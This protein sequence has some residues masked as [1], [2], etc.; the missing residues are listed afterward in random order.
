M[1]A[2][3]KNFKVAE[4]HVSDLLFVPL[5]PK[6]D[7]EQYIK[8]R[9]ATRTKEFEI[10]NA[11]DTV[12]EAYRA[13]LGPRV[14][15]YM[16]AAHAVAT[17][18]GAT[19]AVAEEK[20]LQAEILRKWV[21]YL[22]PTEAVRPHLDEWRQAVSAGKIE[23]AA[24]AYQT[25]FDERWKTWVDRVA[26]WRERV[27]KQLE[28]KDTPLA[29][30]PK[31]NAEQ[32]AF[33]HDVF[34]ADGGPFALGRDDERK[35]FSA[36]TNQQL[37]TLRAELKHLRETAPPEPDM[38]CAVEEGDPVEQ[39]V[40]IRGDYNSLGEPAP[41]IFPAI[42]E[43]F[44]QEPA[45]EGSGRLAL[46]HWLTDPDHPLTA[47]VMVN[48]LWHWHFGEGL[49]RTPSNFGVMGEKPTH[50]ELLDYLSRRFVESGWS[51]KQMHRLMMLS[52]TYQLSSAVSDPQ[53]S[54]DPDNRL[55]SH[56]NRR[57]LQVEEMRDG[58]LALDGSLDTTMGGTLQTGF[59]TDSENSTG[60]LSLSPEESHR[61]LVYVPLRRANLPAL[62]NLFDFGDAT[63]S[64][65]KRMLTNVAPQALFMMNSGFVS[66]RARNLAAALDDKQ[67]SLARAAR[68]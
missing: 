3:T 51:I 1:F 55:L 32:D 48:R 47:R 21:A 29:A 10:D 42:L 33:F 12:L 46:A 44:E 6:Q 26:G 28:E 67:A 11:A 4:S 8:H 57:R 20:G 58:L 22:T 27:K 7:Y 61:R 30:K 65:G 14:A 40:F 15:E 64:T 5:V 49:V 50:P 16:L 62:L 52:S 45:A 2:S 38:A 18:R 43:G 17:G 53:N 35:V 19:A 31:F 63:T 41:K 54:A 9:D 66:E 60:R 23:E 59:G 37:T 36:T 34:F 13:V 24:A 39:R 56:F 68:A 25:R